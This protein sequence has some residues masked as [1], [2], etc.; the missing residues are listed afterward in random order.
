MISIPKIN[1]FPF[2]SIMVTGWL[3]AAFFWWLSYRVSDPIAQNNIG[4]VFGASLGIT[5]LYTITLI[6]IW[7]KRLFKR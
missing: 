2:K 4:E 7:I 1:R 3:L 5:L 6:I